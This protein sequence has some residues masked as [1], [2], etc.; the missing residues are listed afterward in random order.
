MNLPTYNSQTTHILFKLITK[1]K[2]VSE[3]QFSYN[4]FRSRISE[5]R[6]RLTIKETEVDFVNRFKRS[7]SYLRHW[8]SN[9]EKQKAIKLYL[10][11]VKK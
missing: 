3:Q 6:K 10:K 11:L 1:D 7:S 8:I 4:G 9:S 2:G 5:L